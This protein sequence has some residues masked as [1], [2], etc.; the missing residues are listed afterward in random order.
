MKELRDRTDREL[1]DL[2]EEMERLITGNTQDVVQFIIGLVRIDFEL[3]RRRMIE[4]C[5]GSD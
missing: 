3:E 5:R 2:K 1:V 4:E